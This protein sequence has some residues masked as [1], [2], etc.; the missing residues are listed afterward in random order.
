MTRAPRDDVALLRD[1]LKSAEAALRFA[2]GLDERAF[3]ASELHQQA[4]I[5]AIGIVGEAAWRMTPGFKAAHADVPWQAMA[6]MRHRIVHD[7]ADVDLDLVWRVV[8]HELPPLV[9]RLRPLVPRDE[10]A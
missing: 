3:L 9:S 6:G 1:I 7:Y 2:E 5:R 8:V 4:I 10:S